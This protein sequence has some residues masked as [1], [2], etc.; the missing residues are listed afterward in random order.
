MA[1]DNNILTIQNPFTKL[2][3]ESNNM[4]ND[5]LTAATP[6]KIHK[7]YNLGYMNGVLLDV[8]KAPWYVQKYARYNFDYLKN[9]QKDNEP[10][11]LEETKYYSEIKG[12]SK[13]KRV[14]NHKNY[15]KIDSKRAMIG[16]QATGDCVSWAIRTA[17][18]Q[19]RCNKIN[20]GAWEAYIIRQA[21]CG[22]YSGRGHTGQGADPVGLSDFAIDIGTVLEQVY[23]TSK[24]TYDFTDYD[25]YVKWG[26][27]RGRVGIPDDLAELTKK[28]TAGSYKIAA[29][30]DGLADMLVSNGTA[31]VGSMLGVASYGNP[32]SKRS[33]SWAHDMA[34]VGFDDTDECREKFGGRIWLW[35][36]SWG[37]W[38]TVENIPDWW[39]PWAQGMFALNDKD[40]QYAVNDGGCVVFFDGSWFQA[41]P[42]DNLII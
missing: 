19:L 35:D 16:A 18:D 39:K 2:L 40:T 26:I 20:A 25:S 13:G 22:I 23:T 17:L 5:I 24:S 9:N 30:T 6:D 4:N 34:I 42:I 27:S 8:E 28:Y 12:A 14:L 29:T 33:G 31:H 36:Q 21:T 3:P 10:I 37:N 32:I 7:M 1:N 41:D 15:L 38:N 11:I